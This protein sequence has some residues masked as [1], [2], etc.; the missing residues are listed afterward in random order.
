MLS[1]FDGST[2]LLVLIAVGLVCLGFAI[3]ANRGLAKRYT[4]RRITGTP[5]KPIARVVSRHYTEAQAVRARDDY[6]QHSM[7]KGLYT[8]HGR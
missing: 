8:I 2:L 1:H 6:N 7:T 4:V 5:D 3:Y